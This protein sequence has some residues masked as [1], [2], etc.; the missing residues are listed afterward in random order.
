MRMWFLDMFNWGNFLG[1][2]ISCRF[3]QVVS[4]YLINWYFS[5]KKLFVIIDAF[6]AIIKIYLIATNCVLG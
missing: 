5:L 4:L 3:D 2:P 6:E 1:Y